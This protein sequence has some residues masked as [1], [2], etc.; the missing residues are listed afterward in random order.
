MTVTDLIIKHEGLRLKPY[1]CSKGK[2][3]I[4]VGRNIEDNGITENEALHLLDN[5]ISR[6]TKEL[7]RYHWYE[8]LPEQKKAVLIDM[9]FNL[10]LS[11]FKGFKKMIKAIE[12]RDYYRA[13]EEMLDSRWAGQVGDRATELADLMRG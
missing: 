6:V 5:D 7:K 4:G 3:T 1:R 2:L 13:A 9:C 12:D 8:W 10:G 11:R